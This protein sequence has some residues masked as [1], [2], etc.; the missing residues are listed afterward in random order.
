MPD[1]TIV[2]PDDSIHNST[3]KLLQI[4][5][6]YDVFDQDVAVHINSAFATLFQLGVGPQDKAYRITST[7]NKWSEFLLDN[8]D[9]ESVR[10]YMYLKLRLVFDPPGTSFHLEAIKEQ[11][12]ELEWRLNVEREGKFHPWVPQTQGTPLSPS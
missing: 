11:I 6:E 7:A 1:P 9:I 2:S 3:K 5:G 10:T 8:E 12:K 4:P